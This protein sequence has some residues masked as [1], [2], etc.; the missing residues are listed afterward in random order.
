[1]CDNEVL[2]WRMSKLFD[3]LLDILQLF[4]TSLDLLQHIGNLQILLGLFLKF[5]Y[6]LPIVQMDFRPLGPRVETKVLYLLPRCSD[7]FLVQPYARSPGS[8]LLYWLPSLR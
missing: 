5:I 6:S 8:W 1:M 4:G 2:F 7:I 3:T